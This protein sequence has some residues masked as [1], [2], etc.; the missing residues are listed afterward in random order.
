MDNKT[1]VKTY[2]I[3]I[4]L[5]AFMTLVSHEPKSITCKDMKW[6][7]HCAFLCPNYR[8]KYTKLHKIDPSHEP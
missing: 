7:S 2:F 5:K 8:I 3:N 4:Y 6:K 1:I